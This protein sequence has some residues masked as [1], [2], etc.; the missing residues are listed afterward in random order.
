MELARVEEGEGLTGEKLDKHRCCHLGPRSPELVDSL[1]AFALSLFN[2][3]FRGRGGE[4][5]LQGQRALH[6]L[7]EEH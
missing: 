2:S 6:Q 5:R 7:L 3:S 1:G 4:G